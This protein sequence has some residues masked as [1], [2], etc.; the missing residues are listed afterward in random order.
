MPSSAD[1]PVSR[2]S[3]QFH[4]NIE[5]KDLIDIKALSSLKPRKYFHS[6][7]S[8]LCIPLLIALV[9]IHYKLTFPQE[10]IMFQFKIF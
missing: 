6:W 3:S 1:L 7:I 8:Y 10:V 9:F 2:N 4:Y 5:E